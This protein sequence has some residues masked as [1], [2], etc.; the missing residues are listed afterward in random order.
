VWKLLLGT[1]ICLMA[2][3]R[4]SLTPTSSFTRTSRTR[5]PISKPYAAGRTAAEGRMSGGPNSN[6]E[7]RE[8]LALIREHLS[9]FRLNLDRDL[10]P[11]CPR[12][13]C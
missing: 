13:S 10:D 4:Y 7:L 11:A 1:R 12:G 2:A 3:G 8:L 9:R 5:V 6:A